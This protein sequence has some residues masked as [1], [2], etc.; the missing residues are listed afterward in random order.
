ME[1]TVK[2][3]LLN[4]VVAQVKGLIVYIQILQVPFREHFFK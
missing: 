1:N 2:F 3:L 4:I